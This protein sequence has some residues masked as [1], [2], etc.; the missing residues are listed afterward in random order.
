MTE[1]KGTLSL[2]QQEAVKP[3]KKGGTTWLHTNS[4]MWSIKKNTRQK[5][6]KHRSPEVGTLDKKTDRPTREDHLVYM[7]RFK[8]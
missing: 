1:S 4:M 2:N 8:S 5:K 7:C 3:K 6:K